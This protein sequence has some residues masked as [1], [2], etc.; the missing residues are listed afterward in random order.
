MDRDLIDQV[1]D[2]AAHL[3]A[4]AAIGSNMHGNVSIR[5][6]GEDAMYFRAGMPMREHPRDLVVRVGLD[7]TLRE[8]TEPMRAAALQRAMT[9]EAAG[10]QRA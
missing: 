1:M 10:V 9:L 3:A 7:G 4:S 6:P 8:G 5:V 2:T